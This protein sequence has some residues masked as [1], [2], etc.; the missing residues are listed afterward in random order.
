MCHLLSLRVVLLLAALISFAQP[1]STAEG[2][3][4]TL[5]LKP[6]IEALRIADPQ[7]NP[8]LD[9]QGWM[10]EM[11]A[12]PA[13]LSAERAAAFRRAWATF[14]ID[15]RPAEGAWTRPVIVPGEKFFYG[16][17]LWDAAFHVLG[18]KYGGAQARQLALWQIEVVL[19]GQHESGKLPRETWPK[20]AQ[21]FGEGIQAPG[22]MTLAANELYAAAA[23]GAER[24]RMHAAL[25][26]FYPKLVRNH[27]WFFKHADRGRGLCGWQTA[28]SGWDSSPRWDPPGTKEAIDL[29]CF[30]LV[31]RQELARMA[32]TLGKAEEAR[33]WEK[34]A[35][36]LR[37]AIRAGMWDAERGIFNDTR[38][39]GRFSDVITPAIF[40][41]LWAGVATAEEA[42]GVLPYLQNR[43]SL[44]TPWGLPSVAAD[45]P[46]YESENFWR[47][48][49][50]INL[51]WVAI[52]GMQRCGLEK[53]AEA[54]RER[55]LELIARQPVMME[56]YN[57]QIGVGLGCPHYGWT[58][59]L[60][61]DLI[62]NPE[63]G[64]AH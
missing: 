33:A 10:A 23:E 58:S 48:G 24:D 17:W 3:S 34:K 51:N 19:N 37:E 35:G 7:R 31:D 64:A 54:L 26:A 44:G 4:A 39:D 5:E 61:I 57:S 12:L 38:P 53:E 47:G 59:A 28:D 18:L 62:L 11:P 36:A 63:A 21:F 41:P 43:R 8:Y 50:W 25:T 16:I 6:I 1:C 52:R 56:L 9:L 49:T 32:R 13:G 46:S 40:W 15:T 42:R 20:G 30:L 14:W 55:T 2:T 29:N 60:Y 45:D 22:I 27:E